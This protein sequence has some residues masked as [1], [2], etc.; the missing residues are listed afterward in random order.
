MGSA[1]WPPVE[2]FKK[3]KS[4]T[5]RKGNN[6]GRHDNKYI[7]ICIGGAADHVR[8]RESDNMR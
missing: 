5:N 3:P 7:N 4:D 2:D 6:E 8:K 1:C